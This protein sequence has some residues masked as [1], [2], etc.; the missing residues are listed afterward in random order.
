FFSQI[1]GF[2]VD[3]TYGAPTYYAEVSRDRVTFSIRHVNASLA[4]ASGPLRRELEAF[5][6]MVTVDIAKPLYLEFRDN[7]AT[8]FQTLRRE[9]WGSHSFVVEDPD[10]NLL[11]FLDSANASS[12]TD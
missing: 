9:P 1:L 4:G 6:A 10:G 5:D 11:A 12:E 2:A 7:G 3:F 8:F